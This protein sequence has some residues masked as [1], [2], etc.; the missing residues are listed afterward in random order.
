MASGS[1]SVPVWEAP[2]LA[3]SSSSSSSSSGAGSSGGPGAGSAAAARDAR[4]AEYERVVRALFL[5][6]QD[7]VTGLLPASTAVTEHGDYR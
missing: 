2:L 3:P 5:A 4:L 6:R 1:G 7:A